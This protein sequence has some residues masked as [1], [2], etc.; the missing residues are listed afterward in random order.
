MEAYRRKVHYYET[1]KMGVVHPSNYIRYFEEAR[2]D[3]LEQAGCPY[4]RLEAKGLQSPVLAVSCTYKKPAYYGETLLVRVRFVPRGRVRCEFRYEVTEAETGE[5]R[6][7]GGS[8]HCFL[9]ADGRPVSLEKADPDLY[10]TL[11]GIA[12]PDL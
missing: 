10:R 12:G 8:E 4:E 1:D 7:E 5:L 6:A 11:T 9:N 3:W 2:L